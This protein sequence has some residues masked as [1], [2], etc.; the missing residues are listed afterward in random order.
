MPAEIVTLLDDELLKTT[1]PV[2]FSPTFFLPVAE[3]STLTSFANSFF[4]DLMTLDLAFVA[5]LSLKLTVS[6]TVMLV[7]F[8]EI[9]TVACG[10]N[11]IAQTK[12]T[13]KSKAP[14]PINKNFLRNVLKSGTFG[15]LTIFFRES[16][17]LDSFLFASAITLSTAESSSDFFDLFAE[18]AISPTASLPPSI[19]SL[20]SSTFR[21]GI[22]AISGLL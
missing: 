7:V 18:S 1:T 21:T 20:S 19:T 10:A 12:N 6:L 8:A 5:A 2:A 15:F 4:T 14:P 11:Q 16:N 17:P 22:S 13:I 3:N 9:T